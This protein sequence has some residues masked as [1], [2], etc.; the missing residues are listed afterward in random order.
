[1]TSLD[2]KGF[3]ATVR[4]TP[5]HP[6]IRITAVGTPEELRQ[7]LDNIQGESIDTAIESFRRTG[8]WPDQK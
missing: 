6:N 3:S 5:E 1:M 7:L 4:Y 2:D 8:H